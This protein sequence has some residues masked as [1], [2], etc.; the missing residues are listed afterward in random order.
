MTRVT[1]GL[2]CYGRPA[3]FRE[4]LT[5]LLGQSMADF[6][7]LIH[8][9]PSD[10][11]LIRE[12][13]QAA[14]G[15]DPRV[16]YHR[17][18][19]NIGIIGNFMSVLDAAD[20]EFFMWAADDDI[21]HPDTLAALVKLLD[22]SP[23]A[24]L[25]GFSVEVINRPGETIDHHTGFSRF[26]RQGSRLSALDAFLAEPEILG[27]ANLTYGLFRRAALVQAFEAIGG[28]FPTC[29]GPDFVL[30]AAV[31][32]RFPVVATDQIL[33]RKRTNKDHRVPLARRFP[34]D[35]GWPKTEFAAHRAAMLAAMPDEA[36]RDIAMRILDQ[37]HRHLFG[38]PGLARRALLRLMRQEVSPAQIPAA[39]DRWAR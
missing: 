17:H 22:S 14:A 20:T 5:S 33:I 38:V 39:P 13:I 36:M 6:T 28:T 21:R 4:A 29:W 24:A 8:E 19:E 1:I 11:D 2:P 35:Y 31:I 10:S 25:A 18:A 16:R 23:E 27:K 12:T 34:M 30:L 7:L 9:N 26:S 15:D 37:R 32:A 3:V